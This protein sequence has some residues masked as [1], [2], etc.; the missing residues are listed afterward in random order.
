MTPIASAQPITITTKPLNAP[1]TTTKIVTTNVNSKTGLTSCKPT[2]AITTSLRLPTTTVL[3]STT[4]IPKMQQ[5]TN[6]ANSSV[7]SKNEANSPANALTPQQPL[8]VLISS[9]HHSSSNNSNAPTKATSNIVTTSPLTTKKL[10]TVQSAGVNSIIK[11][12]QHINSSSSSSLNVINGTVKSNA[13]ATANGSSL[14][15]KKVNTTTTSVTASQTSK[16][17]AA[18][19]SLSSGGHKVASLNQNLLRSNQATTAIVKNS[20]KTP[21][22]I[23]TATSAVSQP[24]LSSC[25]VSSGSV[26]SSQQQ[27]LA[28]SSSLA[29]SIISPSQLSSDKSTASASSPANNSNSASTNA[30]NSSSTSSSTSSLVDYHEVIDCINP[31][32]IF[33]YRSSYKLIKSESIGGG[34]YEASYVSSSMLETGAAGNRRGIKIENNSSNDE[35]DGYADDDEDDDE[36]IDVVSIG[37]AG[38]GIASQATHNLLSNAHNHHNY[39]NQHTQHNTAAAAFKAKAAAAATVNSNGNTHTKQ[40]LFMKKTSSGESAQS[41]SSLLATCLKAQPKSSQSA[42]STHNA[43]NHPMAT[44]VTKTLNGGGN[45]VGN[46]KAGK[47]ATFIKT[48]KLNGGGQHQKTTVAS[49]NQISMHE[50]PTSVKKNGINK[51]QQQN[52]NGM[53]NSTNIANTINNSNL[54]KKNFFLFQESLNT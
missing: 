32:Q 29:S 24:I 8:V 27:Q 38:T 5:L 48:T 37:N 6:S 34:S 49:N 43:F 14:I 42:G 20:L 1:S 40:I 13:T 12:E 46:M 2:T 30:N 9:S 28:H 16:S 15:L 45:K 19:L 18:P 11:S 22:T 10:T 47:S 39:Y 35:D 26:S 50:Q 23:T 3:S 44:I 53:S 33:P 51:K 41:G 7:V 36:E 54:G 17:M 52:I 31:D 21:L 4:T 25:A